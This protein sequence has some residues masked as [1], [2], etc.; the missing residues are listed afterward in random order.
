M[1]AYGGSRG[2]VVH[3]LNLDARWWRVVTIIPWLLD[4]PRKELWYLLNRR[5]GGSMSKSR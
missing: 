4:P 5:L 2:I 1:N 3:I